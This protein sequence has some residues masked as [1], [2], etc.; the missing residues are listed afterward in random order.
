M[1]YKLVGWVR[2][3]ILLILVHNILVLY[4]FYTTS[5][6]IYS[7]KPF[8]ISMIPLWMAYIDR[9]Y[10]YKSNDDIQEESI[11]IFALFFVHGILK[12]LGQGKPYSFRMSRN[13]PFLLTRLHP[14]ISPC[15]FECSSLYLYFSINNIVEKHKPKKYEN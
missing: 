14:K 3:E 13:F 15:L 7:Q 6:L 2:V 8:L 12:L 4:L 11:P 10:G 9:L 1:R 5:A